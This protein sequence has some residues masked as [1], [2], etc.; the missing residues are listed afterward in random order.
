[1]ADTDSVAGRR[2]SH[3]RQAVVEGIER[4]KVAALF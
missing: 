1:M 4:K 3:D 2:A